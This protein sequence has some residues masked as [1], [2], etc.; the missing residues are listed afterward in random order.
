[1][2]CFY[3]IYS[4][5]SKPT[6]IYKQTADQP[7]RCFDSGVYFLH[8]VALIYSVLQIDIIILIVPTEVTFREHFQHSL[9]FGEV[10]LYFL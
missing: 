10:S 8:C 7:D 3:D 5:I 6:Q 9:H 1:M 2:Y 4:H